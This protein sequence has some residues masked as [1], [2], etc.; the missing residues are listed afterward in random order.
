MSLWTNSWRWIS[1]QSDRDPEELLEAHKGAQQVYRGSGGSLFQHGS[2]CPSVTL[3]GERP[4]NEV[5]IEVAGYLMFL[6][7]A[8]QQSGRRKVPRGGLEQKA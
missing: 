5:G 4:G 1:D 3:Q 2:H 7:Q 6:L 8:T